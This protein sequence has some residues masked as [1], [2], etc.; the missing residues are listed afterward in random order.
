MTGGR[1]TV[2]TTYWRW[3]PEP[4]RVVLLAHTAQAARPGREAVAGVAEVWGAEGRERVLLA[5]AEGVHALRG[6]GGVRLPDGTTWQVRR[7]GCG[8]QV[9]QALKGYAPRVAA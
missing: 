8:C 4:R 2:V 7:P 1:A 9:P 6:G 5:R 3:G